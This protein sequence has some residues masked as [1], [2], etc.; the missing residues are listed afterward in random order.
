[1]LPS[2]KA[3]MVAVFNW[4]WKPSGGLA[5]RLGPPPPQVGVR[6]GMGGW[7]VNVNDVDHSSN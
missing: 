4:R 5:R 1:M 2:P 7:I 6:E 3:T